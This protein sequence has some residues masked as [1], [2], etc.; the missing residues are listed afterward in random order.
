MV[1][2]RVTTLAAKAATGGFDTSLTGTA[3]WPGF[4]SA[5]EIT[6]VIVPSDGTSITFAGTDFITSG[7]SPTTVACNPDVTGLVVSPCFL[8]TAA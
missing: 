7:A 2:N 5:A 8:N 1:G 3:N 6:D 4:I